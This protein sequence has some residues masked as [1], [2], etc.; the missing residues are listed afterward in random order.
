MALPTDQKVG[1]S[2]PS[3]RAIERMGAPLLAGA[4]VVGLAVGFGAQKFVQ[5]IIT[6]AFIQI[7]NAMN[8]GDIVE[9]NGVSGTV[10]QLTVRSVG[11]RTLD[12]TW[13]L[14]PFSSVDQVANFSKDFAY[15]VA[16]LGVAYR[17]NV[18]D[19]KQLMQDAFDEMKE[20]PVADNLISGFDMW[21]VNELGDSAVVVRG[22]V[23]TKPGTQW[24]VGRAY[25][26]IVKR[27]ADERGIEIPFPHM[28]V[29]FG[30]D[31]KGKAPPIHVAQ[32][33]VSTT[34]EPA[35]IAETPEGELGKASA[36][37]A[38]RRG[39][40]A[41][42]IHDADGRPIPPDQGDIDSAGGGRG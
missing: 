32:D 24:G 15:Y 29:W 5:D 8:E 42:G 2:S 1:G 21:G 38:A 10:E 17:E 33:A 23:M 14:I 31:R 12:G 19:V 37:Q 13:Y 4:G 35:Q 11:I 27:M 6:G 40:D 26:E 16:D 7:Q 20:G 41:Y 9:V 18:D 30:E 36:N 34:A 25:R 39:D 3:E 22:R 28:T